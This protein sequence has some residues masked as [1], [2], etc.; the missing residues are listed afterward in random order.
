MPAHIFLPSDDSSGWGGDVAA[1][2]L[3]EARRRRHDIPNRDGHLKNCR[4]YLGAT[5]LLFV[6]LIIP[7]P[8][9]AQQ[10]GNVILDS[11]EQLFSVAAA[12]NASGYD[13][14][15]GIDT[16]NNTREV[17]RA[18]LAKKKIP[19]IAEIRTFYE[20][21]KIA[22]DPGADLG[23]YVSL[24]L[25]LGPPPDFKITV[26]QS[27]LPPDAKA[28]AGI[29]PLLKT[30][31]QQADLLDLWSR[32][33]SRYQDEIARYSDSVRTSIGLA[34]AYLRFPSGAYLGRTCAIYLSLLGAPD[35]V[36]A[37]IY[38]S[39]YFLVVTPS[40][41]SKLDE[42][43]H[44]YLH[45]LLDPLA[46]KYAQDI[47][48]KAELRVAVRQAPMLAEDFKQDFPLLLTECLIRAVELRMD[49]QPKAAAEKALQDFTASGLV[50]TPYFYSALADFEK[51]DTSMNVY[52]KAMVQGIDVDEETKKLA[53]VKFM[54]RP[55]VPENKK[56]SSL[57]E[58]QRL[59]DQAENSIFLGHYDEAKTTFQTVLE[60]IDP[61]SDR[62]LY[63]LAAAE[64]YT[65]KPDLAEENFKKALDATHDLHIATWSHIYLGRIY[66]LKGKR[67]D[68]LAQY[69]AASLTATA[70]P[71]ALRAVQAGLQEPYGSK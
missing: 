18:F 43:R 63:G 12:L 60:K 5:L 46:V 51:Q 57:T 21:H 35:Q 48:E 52:Y 62:A 23:Q 24:A 1:G 67:E 45:F 38:G 25:L 44:Q 36:Q 26:P 53:S 39:N 71:E 20:A 33:E 28:V 42:I 59:L 27:D 61:K 56:A 70:Y 13:T 22:D 54:E 16:G 69:R 29:V 31:Y 4:K 8:G 47:H 68:A 2:N 40:K 7:Q 17:V 64:T 50:L 10:S 55:P 37:R 49:K 6:A 41:Q 14:G 66:D 32:L 34:D 30:F 65:R 3:H 11:N 15:V 9:K 19:V 58:E